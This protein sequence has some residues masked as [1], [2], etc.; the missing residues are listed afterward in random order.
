M[1]KNSYSSSPAAATGARHLLAACVDRRHCH[2]RRGGQGRRDCLELVVPVVEEVL[3]QSAA[4]QDNV[5]VVVRHCVDDVEGGGR[6]LTKI[7]TKNLKNKIVMSG[8]Y[9]AGCGTN[10]GLKFGL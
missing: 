2:G 8:Q 4:L 5:L 10:K 9:C 7:K 1:V 3:V 6:D